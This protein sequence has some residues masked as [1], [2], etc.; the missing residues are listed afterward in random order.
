MK[1]IA[2]A[3]SFLVFSGCAEKTPEIDTWKAELEL[4]E[5]TLFPTVVEIKPYRDALLA[6]RYRILSVTGEKPETPIFLADELILLHW[7]IHKDQPV[8]AV[9]NLKP[10]DRKTFRIQRRSDRPD[11][12]GR[13]VK[14]GL[15]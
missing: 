1:K 12:D 5:T 10:G 9:K 3:V 2:V 15:E 14:N 13:Y 8:A 11:L 6:H 7:A 4:L